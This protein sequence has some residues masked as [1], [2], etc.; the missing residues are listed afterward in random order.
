M[1]AKRRARACGGTAVIGGRRSSVD[2]LL[3]SIALPGFGQLLNGRLVKGIVL[4]VLEFLVNV[5]ARLNLV[6]MSSFQGNIEMAIQL[7]D[8]QWLLFYP[9]LY[10]FA[11]WDGF[12]DAGGGASPYAAIP[13][14]L[15]A[16]FGTVGI[17]Y[18]P[19]Y[20]PFGILWGPVWLPMAFALGGAA[21]GIA[22]QWYLTRREAK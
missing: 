9:C 16:F 8:F 4:I 10:M 21:I 18:S 3:W 13:F 1:E 15:A 12:R 17:M 22:V 5:H 6:I 2:T 20:R 7:V 11:I 19:T 14:A